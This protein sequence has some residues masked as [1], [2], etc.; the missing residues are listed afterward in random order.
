[1]ARIRNVCLQT[2]E[3]L[4]ITSRHLAMTPVYFPRRS[5]SPAVPAC[6]P[7]LPSSNFPSWSCW[8][9]LLWVAGIIIRPPSP[10]A[11]PSAPCRNLCNS[12]TLFI[13]SQA[14]NNCSVITH[15]SS[16]QLVMGERKKKRSRWG[17]HQAT[18]VVIKVLFKWTQGAFLTHMLFASI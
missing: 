1:M 10:G 15:H 7:A 9:A 11:I 6:H 14:L 8:P 5:D 13:R 4:L 12:E 18:L 16:W 17:E 3:G 2:A